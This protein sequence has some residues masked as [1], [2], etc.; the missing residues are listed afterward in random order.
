MAFE[1]IECQQ[2]ARDLF[3]KYAMLMFEN[4]ESIENSEKNALFGL[5]IPLSV[6]D[7]LAKSEPKLNLFYLSAK[8]LE[9][10]ILNGMEQVEDVTK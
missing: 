9:I 5:R 1:F 7:L 3:P 4:E 10:K 8:C 6:M 2:H